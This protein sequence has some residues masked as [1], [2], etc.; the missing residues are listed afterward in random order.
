MPTRCLIQIRWPETFI[1]NPVQNLG[2]PVLRDSTLIE[3][4]TCRDYPLTRIFW[5]R[6]SLLFSKKTSA[7]PG[8]RRHLYPPPPHLSWAIP[9]QHFLWMRDLLCSWRKTVTSLHL[10]ERPLCTCMDEELRYI[11]RF[12]VSR[13]GHESKIVSYSAEML[14]LVEIT[15][16]ISF[17]APSYPTIIKS[18]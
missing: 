18:P 3:N 15:L 7:I 2:F 13:Y 9:P 17:D 16:F 12:S 8:I 14:K 11:C 6:F 1:F 10:F 4:L 5:G